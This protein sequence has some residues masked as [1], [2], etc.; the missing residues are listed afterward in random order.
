MPH[1]IPGRQLERKNEEGRREKEGM[2]FLGLK[3]KV[4]KSWK[5]EKKGRMKQ[6]ERE[7]KKE[8]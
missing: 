7:K 4:V 1:W 6:R 5:R 2:Y 8:E 3:V